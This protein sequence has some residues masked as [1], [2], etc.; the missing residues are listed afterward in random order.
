MSVL[1]KGIGRKVGSAEGWREFGG[2]VESA[3]PEE[4]RE[5]QI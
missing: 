2:A 4:K 3:K 5:F 1:L